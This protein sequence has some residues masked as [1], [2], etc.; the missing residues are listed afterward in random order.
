MK[1]FI[2]V[3]LDGWERELRRYRKLTLKGW[4][5]II[6]EQ[7]RLLLLRMVK[8]TPPRTRAQGRRKIDA[9][10]RRVFA[11]FGDVRFDAPRLNNPRFRKAWRQNDYHIIQRFLGPGNFTEGY[12]LASIPD[13]QVHQTAR[14]D[15]GAVSR[16]RQPHVAITRRG[17]LR[18]YIRDIQQRVGIAK[19]GWIAAARDTH[20]RLPQWL[21]AHGLRYSTRVDRATRRRNPYYEAHNKAHHLAQLNRG[22]KIVEFA[23][24]ARARDMQKRVNHLIKSSARKCRWRV[25]F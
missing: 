1:P 25:T 8:A 14:K 19:A 20:A 5:E 6:R 7:M 21:N 2:H 16:H 17:K 10:I 4:P 23:L 9:D 15:Y 13:Y 18:A 12:R 3:S 22:G 24:R 11:D